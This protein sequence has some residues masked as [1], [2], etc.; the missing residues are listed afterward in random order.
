M[1]GY[2]AKMKDV[3]CSP[4]QRM[5]VK[6]VDYGNFDQ[7]GTFNA[8]AR[9][10]T[11]CSMITSCRVKSLCGG[12]RSCELTMDNNILLSQYCSDT[13]KEIY[14]EY[15]CVDNSPT[16]ITGSYVFIILK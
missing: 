1:T 16:V 5:V 3:Q 2:N 6:K 4:I 7:S 13:S 10:D 14:T 15:T 12:N 11:A 9:I 8:N